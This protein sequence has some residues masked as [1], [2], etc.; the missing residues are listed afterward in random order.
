MAIA[1]HGKIAR[2]AADS[3]MGAGCPRDFI[4]S[5]YLQDSVFYLLIAQRSL[6]FFRKIEMKEL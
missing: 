6:S 1:N 2:A 5:S 3:T 4:K